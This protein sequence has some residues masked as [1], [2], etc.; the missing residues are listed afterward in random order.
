MVNPDGY[1]HTIRS[2]GEGEKGNFPLSVF[3]FFHF[4][5]HTS[6]ERYWRKT[7]TENEPWEGTGICM[8]TDANRNYGLHW[9]EEGASS[10][11]C[12]EAFMGSAAWSEVENRQSGDGTLQ[13]LRCC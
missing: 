9:G 5:P 3:H 13:V 2:V 4:T 7:R 11:P 8:G 6:E 12:D 10:N 1:R